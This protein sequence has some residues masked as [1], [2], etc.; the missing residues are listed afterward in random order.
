MPAGP[1]KAS[2]DENHGGQRVHLRQPAQGIEHEDVA[3]AP[4][5]VGA[6]SAERRTARARD[7]VRH[8]RET[9][10]R[11]GAITRTSAWTP[12]QGNENAATRL[13]FAFERAAGDPQRAGSGPVLAKRARH[14]G[15]RLR[16]AQRVVL[17]VPTT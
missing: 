16:L 14:G 4:S 1:D 8:R 15:R 11:R 9:L 17:E 2:T 10:R 7:Q 12:T 6:G 13:L 5:P 3:A